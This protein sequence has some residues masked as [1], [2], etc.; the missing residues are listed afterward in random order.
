M[1]RSSIFSYLCRIMFK[2]PWNFK[3]LKY[4][5]HN[6]IYKGIKNSNYRT[7]YSVDFL[8]KLISIK[9]LRRG[10]VI[11]ITALSHTTV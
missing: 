9:K 4:Q 2:S 8:V 10:I 7:Q 5:I 6:S 1:D 11:L 3:K